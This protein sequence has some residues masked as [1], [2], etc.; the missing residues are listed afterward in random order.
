LVFGLVRGTGAFA[1]VLPSFALVSRIPFTHHN[2]DFDHFF[3]TTN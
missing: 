1:S 3:V 2:H